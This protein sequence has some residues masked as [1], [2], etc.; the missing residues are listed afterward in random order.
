MDMHKNARLTPLGRAELVRRV[1][2]EGQPHSAVA[3]AFGICDKTVGKWVERFQAKGAAGLED[4]SLRPHRL[5]EPTAQATC[6]QIVELRRRRWT[7]KQVAQAAVVSP[8]TV[9]RV[10]RR[11][12]SA[13][14]ATW[15]RLSWFAATSARSR[16]N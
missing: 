1:L 15:S 13:G 4:R 2:E 5:R 14:C 9:S 10:L 3:A 6:E 7:G 12:A 16:A 8:A 11:P